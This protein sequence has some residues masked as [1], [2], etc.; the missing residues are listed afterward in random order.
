MMTADE[1]VPFD[2]KGSGV[3]SLVDGKGGGEGRQDS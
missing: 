2:G 3:G 1:E